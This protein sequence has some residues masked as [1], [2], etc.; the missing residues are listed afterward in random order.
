MTSPSASEIDD[1]AAGWAIQLGDQADAPGLQ[2][3]LDGDRR[4]AGALLRAQA[5]LS[6]IDRARALE[7]ASATASPARQTVSR[8]SV[9]AL[10]GGGALAAAGIG[11]VAVLGGRTR[12]VTDLGEIRRI[13]LSDGSVVDIN[14]SSSL[15]VALHSRGRDVTLRQGEA[16][17]QVAKDAR[18][19]FLVKAGDARFRAVGTAFS[20]RRLADQQAEMLVTEGVVEAWLQGGERVRVEAGSRIALGPGLPM[21]PA[22]APVERALAWRNGQI[23]LEGLTLAQ[24]AAEFNRYNRRRLVIETPALAGQ[25]FVGLFRVDDPQS[26]AKA[27]SAASGARLVED[28]TTL[29]LR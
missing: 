9:L 18:R 14:T 29:R 21:R 10:A 27:V 8:R 2:A 24:A 28:E 22:P 7:P 13:P 26:F 11:A 17:F 4:R 23:S 6:F 5:P 16:W 20:V 19:P 25:Q 1:E 3:W 15:E 12:Y